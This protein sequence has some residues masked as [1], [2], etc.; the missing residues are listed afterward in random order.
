MRL[1]DFHTHLPNIERYRGDSSVIA[2]RSL[3]PDEEVD[4]RSDLFTIGIHPMDRQRYSDPEG[5]LPGGS[6]SWASDFSASES[7]DGIID[8]SALWRSRLP[9]CDAK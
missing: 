5:L 6:M 2:V 4:D 8:R 3:M 1:L 9:S 7:V